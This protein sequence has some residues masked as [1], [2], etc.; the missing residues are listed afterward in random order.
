MQS[1]KDH[2]LFTAVRQCWTVLR[3]PIL[4]NIDQL[5]ALLTTQSLD[6]HHVEVLDQNPASGSL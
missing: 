5:F 3:E 1:T 4:N 2:N 6:L